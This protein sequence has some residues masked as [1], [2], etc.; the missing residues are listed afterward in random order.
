MIKNAVLL[1][2]ILVI[3]ENPCTQNIIALAKKKEWQDSEHS[4]KTNYWWTGSNW[5]DRKSEVNV[6]KSWN[7]RPG[8]N[9]ERG[10]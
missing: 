2:F 5:M 9:V 4:R 8:S 10:G 1:N 6:E 3:W 7:A